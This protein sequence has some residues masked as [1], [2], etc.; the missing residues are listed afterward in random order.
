MLRRIEAGP[1]PLE[2]T[3]TIDHLEALKES[4]GVTALDPFLLPIDIMLDGFDKV[5]LNNEQTGSILQGQAVRIAHTI[6][7]GLI[8]VYSN[9]EEQGERFLGMAEV[10]DD[11]E[12]AP[13]RLVNFE[14]SD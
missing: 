1:F 7:S 4:E 3:V 5:C 13:R 14:S 9:D 11:G 10:M 12:I 8:R 6:K 2:Q